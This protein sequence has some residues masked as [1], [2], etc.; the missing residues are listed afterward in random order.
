MRLS[1]AP[2]SH[3][4]HNTL[5]TK[6]EEVQIMRSFS[7]ALLSIFVAALLL[8]SPIQA[9][10]RVKLTGEEIREILFTPG[11]VIYGVNHLHNTI[12]IGTALGEGDRHFYWRSLASRSPRTNPPAHGELTGTAK[13]VNDQQCAVGYAEDRCFDIYR[14]GDKYESWSGD[15]LVT[16]WYRAN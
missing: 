12:W 16:T 14:I 1:D 3:A 6:K 11:N 5:S 9:E 8:A 7:G 13:I 10:D 15:T 2:K 4:V